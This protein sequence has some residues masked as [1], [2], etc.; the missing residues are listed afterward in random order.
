M[1]TLI[2]LNSKELMLSLV[3]VYT[4]QS[5]Y[6]YENIKAK[7]WVFACSVWMI[8][9]YQSGVLWLKW[10]FLKKQDAVGLT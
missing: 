1:I 7:E 6:C 5:M 4:F 10:K 8:E 3:S 2:N 9:P